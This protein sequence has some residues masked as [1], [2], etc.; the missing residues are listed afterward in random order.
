MPS[1]THHYDAIVIGAGPA[2]S[3]AALRLAES[4]LSVLL[5]EK[6]RLPRE[7]PCGGGLTPKAWP[8]LPVPI[9][10][11]VLNRATSVRVQRGKGPSVRFRARRWAIWMV[12]RQELDLRLAR[13]AARRGVDLHEGETLRSMERGNEIRVV[14]DRDSYQARVLIGADG[15]ESRVAREL[16]LPRPHRWMVALE[17]EV[18]VE[19]DPLAGEALVNLGVPHGYGWVFP[20]G[21]LYNVGLGTFHPGHAGELR[22]RF[23]R[24]V[25]ETGLFTNRTLA[26]VGHRIPTGLPPGPLHRDNALLVGDAA[27]VA[28]PYFGEGISYALLTAHLASTAVVEYLAGRSASLS[29][30]TERVKAALGADMRLWR[31]VAAVLHRCPGLGLKALAASGALQAQVERTIAGELGFCRKWCRTGIEWD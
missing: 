22:S 14:S 19:G 3:T 31:L 13:E 7:K 27:G 11:L 29:S 12:R 10:D 20:K 25:E 1:A 8:L 16:G 17:T 23:R 18:E 2:G 15:A 21:R 24:F 26:P 6:E 28:D 4:G 30:Y 5:M 9:D